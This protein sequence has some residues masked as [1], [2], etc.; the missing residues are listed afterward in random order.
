MGEKRIGH[1]LQLD[2]MRHAFEPRRI[3]RGHHRI[4]QFP[5][6]AGRILECAVAVYHDFNL[7]ARFRLQPLGNRRDEC[8]GPARKQL[9]PLGVGRIAAQ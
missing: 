4:C 8:G 7:P 9:D 3:G 6:L 5:D 2:F 1:K